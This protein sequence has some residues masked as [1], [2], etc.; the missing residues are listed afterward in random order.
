MGDLKRDSPEWGERN[1]VYFKW[2]NCT[3][4]TLKRIRLNYETNIV[5]NEMNGRDE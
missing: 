1:G 4:G 3:I 2:Y 5:V